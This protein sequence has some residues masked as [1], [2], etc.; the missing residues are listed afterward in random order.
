[1]ISS[2]LKQM[3]SYLSISHSLKDQQYIRHEHQTLVSGTNYLFQH[4]FNNSFF[5]LFFARFGIFKGQQH[6]VLIM[7]IGH[8]VDELIMEIFHWG[9]QLCPLFKTSPSTFKG[10]VKLSVTWSFTP[11]LQISHDISLVSAVVHPLQFALHYELSSRPTAEGRMP[12]KQTGDQSFLPVQIQAS[13]V[14]S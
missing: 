3:G 9:T 11:V 14:I 1:M 4:S 7:E 5:I 2:S 13:P 10:V 8:T 6:V 12:G